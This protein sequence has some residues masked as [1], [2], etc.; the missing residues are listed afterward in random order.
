M[1]CSLIHCGSMG[2]IWVWVAPVLC[3]VHLW[4]AGVRSVFFKGIFLLCFFDIL[5]L[6]YFGTNFCVLLL[7]GFT[8]KGVMCVNYNIYFLQWWVWPFWVVCLLSFFLLLFFFFSVFMFCLSCWVGGGYFF[9]P[10]F[11]SFVHLFIIWSFLCLWAHV[12]LLSES[13]I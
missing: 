10:F 2:L 3:S 1:I 13:I 4:C 5:L 9:F 6:F 8:G 7:R 12:Y 11:F